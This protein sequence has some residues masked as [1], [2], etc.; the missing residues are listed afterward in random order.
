MRLFIAEKPSLAKAIAAVLPGPQKR[1]KT[2]IESGDQNIVAWCAGHI[3]TPYLPEDY[4]KKY[5]RW[6][7][8][9]LPIVPN[10]WQLKVADRTR[11]LYATIKRFAAMADLIVHCGDPDREGQLLVDEVLESI[12][13]DT[14]VKRVLILDMNGSAVRRAIARMADNSAFAGLRDAAAGR[15][16]ADWLYGLNLTR[17][18]TVK[19]RAG[20][21]DGVLS[22]GRV[23]TPVL[24]LVVR[25]DRAIDR[26]ESKPYYTLTAEID[27]PEG[28]FTGKWETSEKSAAVQDDEGRIIDRGFLEA[29]QDQLQGQPGK[30]SQCDRKNGKQRPPLPFSLPELQK[31]A[32]QGRGLSAKRTLDIAQALYERQQVLTYPRSDCQY[33]PQE[34]WADGGVIR[35][36]IVQ[37]IGEDHPLYELTEKINLIERSPC[38]NDKKVTAH[39]AIIPT[40]KWVALDRLTDDE[41]WVY[42]QVALR[43]LLQ[44]SGDRTYHQTDVTVKI[45]TPG[46]FE[47]FRA[48]GT[49]DIELGWTAYRSILT[50]RDAKANDKDDADNVTLPPLEL[51]QPVTV[52]SLAIA[53][54]M[55]T[56]P[57]RF[58]VAS[59]LDAMTGIARFVDDPEL[60]A[61]L[62]DTDGLGTP[63]TQADMI[64]T[65]SRREYIEK[66]GKAIKA[67]ALGCELIDNLPLEVTL[68][69]M[70]AHWEM[71]L[72]GIAEGQGDLEHFMN[73]VKLKV[74]N[75]TAV[76]KSQAL[77]SLTV[78]DKKPAPKKK[79]QHIYRCPSKSCDGRLRRIKAKKGT[80]WGCT[81][82]KTGCKETR[83]DN[84]GRPVMTKKRASSSSSPSQRK[85]S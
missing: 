18:Y 30:V 34:Q 83:P 80:F 73:A 53:D 63:A 35:D 38:W 44:F 58:T 23:Q 31:I 52:A 33:L 27:A 78:V 85:A 46:S 14:P 72:R 7:E 64:E 17:L 77:P 41:R 61:I 71:Q 55:T 66:I 82:F 49:V 59:L 1:H 56:P 20:G 5:K 11:E 84:R 39:H 29:L 50:T 43:Y 74:V 60:K 15:S 8:D 4:D 68:P 45:P 70:T 22:V 36:A 2:Y 19:G 47:R 76:V 3:M 62:K 21:Y 65:L 48:R 26:F 51:D 32:S 57:K 37:S 25:R 40:G 79:A 81:N 13:V 24:G 67:T 54:K 12:G 9:D 16:R 10:A 6:H 75:L 42:E 69:D 28:R